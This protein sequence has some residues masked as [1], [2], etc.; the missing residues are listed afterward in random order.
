M[1]LRGHWGRWE[2]VGDTP[3]EERDCG[4]AKRK[5]KLAQGMTGSSMP[6]E[7]ETK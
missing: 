2:G 6:H 7:E 1:R 5:G 3:K 4:T